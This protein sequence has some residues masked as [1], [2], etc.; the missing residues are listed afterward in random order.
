[1]G[2]IMVIDVLNMIL[3][4]IRILEVLHVKFED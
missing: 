4:W 3:R 2:F 1:M